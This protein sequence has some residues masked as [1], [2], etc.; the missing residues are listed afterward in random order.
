MRKKKIIGIVL[1]AALVAAGLGG[2]AYANN[3]SLEPMTGQKLVGQGT[4]A[5]WEDNGILNYMDAYILLTNPDCVSEITIDR[6]S[7]FT[8]DGILV[9]EDPLRV[10]VDGGWEEY[11]GPMKPH[12]T[13]ETVLSFYDLPGGDREVDMVY[14][15]EIFWTWADKKGLPLIGWISGALVRR[16]NGGELEF[17]GVT[18]MVNMEQIRT[19]EK[20][21]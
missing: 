14:T 6:I 15:V 11:T 12:Q 5:E 8:Y 18:Q 20:V 3:G 7:V 13:L 17:A 1:A 10:K 2:F 9:Y 19:P 16:D 21:K 4:Y